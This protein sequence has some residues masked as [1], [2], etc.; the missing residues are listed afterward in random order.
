[1][2]KSLY[3][4][5]YRNINE[6]TIDSLAR[7]NLITGKNNVGKTSILE[8]LIINASKIRMNVLYFL[9]LTREENLN[10]S[11][12]KKD[13]IQY[14]LNALST[15]FK[16]N[17]KNFDK[18]NKIIIGEKKDVEFNSVQLSFVY[19]KEKIIDG[20]VE[21]KIL[22]EDANKYPDCKQGF[23]IGV[24][25]K[26]HII[27]LGNDKLGESDLGPS[28]KKNS[29]SFVSTRVNSGENNNEIYWGEI[30]LTEN[31]IYVI[32]A[33]QL[34]D[35]RIEAFS[36]LKDENNKSKETVKLKNSATPVVLSSMGDGIKKILTIILAL[37]HS[38]DGYLFID[39][40]ENGLH[41]SVQ[42]QLWD[43][44][45]KV[46]KKLNVQVFA[47]SHS[48]DSIASFSAILNKD[49][50]GNVGKLIR[51]DNKKEIIKVTEYTT[52]QVS[53]SVEN[54]FEVR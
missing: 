34:A 26:Q 22:V 45:F 28:Y 44:I 51:L 1:M 14:N 13:P 9:L 6:L 25:D 37:I 42:E 32:E 4:K 10:P 17:N 24:N 36:F 3:I 11:G 5:N 49:D 53:I 33:L 46:S 30:A 27:D 47:T 35:P 40:I 31:E 38:K 52:E 41:Y 43:I 8:A 16:N 29:I 2:L 12:G 20:V 18:E 39:E 15:F 54:H 21:E 7:I 19:F 23:M 48:M 50:N